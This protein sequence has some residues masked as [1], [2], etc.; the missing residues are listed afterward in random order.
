MLEWSVVL[1]LI[2]DGDTIGPANTDIDQDGPLRTIQPRPLDTGIL[3]PL[4]PEQ[5]A[6]NTNT[7]RHSDNFFSNQ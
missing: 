2:V 3:T 5:V 6:A 4:C 1:Y 7:A